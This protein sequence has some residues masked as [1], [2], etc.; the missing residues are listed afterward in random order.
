MLR[1]FF[2]DKDGKL[3]LA[4]LAPKAACYG[5]GGIKGG[6]EP[7]RLAIANGVL[8][9]SFDGGSRQTRSLTTKWRFQNGEFALIGVAETLMDSIAGDN[10]AIVSIARDANLSTR[11]MVET[12]RRV[13]G[14]TPGNGEIETKLESKRCKIGATFRA[15]KLKDLDYEAVPVPRCTNLELP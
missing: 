7:Y 3:T 1:V 5:C 15:P 6:D 2:A 11:K 8:S 14:I 10:G 4:A 9:L 13:T 12:V